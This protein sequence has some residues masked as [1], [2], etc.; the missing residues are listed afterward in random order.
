M[1]TILLI[2]SHPR[3]STSSEILLS[4]ID[5]SDPVQFNK[6]SLS[7]EDRLKLLKT[8]WIPSSNSY[9]Y[10]KN[11]QNRRYNK[12]WENHYSWLRYSPSQDG[13]Y[14]SLCIAFQDH[15]SENPRYNEFVTI[16]FND[17]KNALGERRGRLALHSNSERHLKVLEKSGLLLSVSDQRRPSVVQSIS[18][19]YS[20]KF[21]KNRASLLSLLD[22]FNIDETTGT[23]YSLTI[24][25]PGGNVNQ[26]QTYGFLILLSSATVAVTAERLT[27]DTANTN[28]GTPT[29]SP[30]PKTICEQETQTISYYIKELYEVHQDDYR[31]CG[32]VQLDSR[33]MWIIACMLKSATIIA[34]AAAFRIISNSPPIPINVNLTMGTNNTSSINFIQK[35]GF[36]DKVTMGVARIERTPLEHSLM[37]RRFISGQR[38]DDRVLDLDDLILTPMKTVD[39]LA[40]LSVRFLT[41]RD[42]PYFDRLIFGFEDKVTMGVARIERTPL[43]HSLMLRRFISGQRPDDRV[44]DLDDLILTPMKTVD[45]L[46]ELSVRFLTDRDFP[47]FDRLIFGF[48]DKVTMGV[49]RIER[50]PLEHS[51]MLRRFISGQRPDDRV[52]DLDDLILTPMKT[53]DELAELSVRFLTDRISPTL[54]D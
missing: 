3:D 38:P 15:P 33:T 17:W 20:D 21:E 19:A 14:C 27:V 40:E 4:P 42:F 26:H 18:K 12:S 36:E 1:V 53:V 25:A 43:E 10:P 11:N 54:I 9:I 48:E 46:A 32:E 47:Y 2:P 50:T 5:Y 23:I 39:E 6:R 34:A 30:V 52:L 51:L 37:L 22:A 49:A 28:Q 31:I 13:A 24:Q 44:L 16:P 45:E 41:D 35:K 29:L 8:K 7:D